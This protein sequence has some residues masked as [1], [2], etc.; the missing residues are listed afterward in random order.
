MELN[1]SLS[2]KNSTAVIVFIVNKNR[3]YFKMNHRNK[4]HGMLLPNGK[5][6]ISHL[7]QHN[8]NPPTPSSGCEALDVVMSA[9]CQSADGFYK[10][11][12]VSWAEAGRVGPG[13]R[14]NTAQSHFIALPKRNHQGVLAKPAPME[15]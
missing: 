2:L 15:G 6:F 11:V 10:R 14:N 12:K 8:N 9:S 5:M 4:G 7:L 13:V 1:E 3:D